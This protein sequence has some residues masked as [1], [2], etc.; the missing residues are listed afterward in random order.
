[1]SGLIPLVIIAV[2]GLTLAAGAA[3]ADCMKNL[4]GE[5]IC[6]KGECRRD[7]RGMVFC[8]AFRRGSAV[9]ASDGMILCGKGDCV[10]TSSA[11][12][13]C[14]TVEEGT[15]VKDRYGHPRCEG[16]CEPASVD[17]CEAIPAGT[18]LE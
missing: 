8:S 10:R 4:N 16:R 17:Y 11:E 14:S 13:Y 1:M 7:L 2:T 3:N 9:R 5:V 12:V 18:A 15:A 6:G